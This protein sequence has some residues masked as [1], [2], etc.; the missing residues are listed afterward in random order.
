MDQKVAFNTR[1]SHSPAVNGAT[2]DTKDRTA[3][4]K[5]FCRPVKSHL[6]AVHLSKKTNLLLV[7]TPVACSS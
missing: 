3:Y 5:N 7:I 2:W 1:D 6:N 4:A